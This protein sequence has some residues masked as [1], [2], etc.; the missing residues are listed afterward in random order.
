MEGLASPRIEAQAAGARPWLLLLVL[1][2]TL[3]GA[4]GAA[5]CVVAATVAAFP[6]GMTLSVPDGSADLPLSTEIQVG[7]TGWDTRIVTAEL[8][9]ASVA[10]GGTSGAERP[11]P[12]Q[13][14]ILRASQ[15]PDGTDL[16]L[17][18]AAGSLDADA[19]YR[20][21]LR[22]SALTAALPWP[23]ASPVEREVRFTTLR[24]PTPRALAGPVHLKWSQPLQIQWDA[25]V[26]DVRYEVTPPTPIQTA[27]DPSSHRASS[28]VLTDP[29]DGQTYQIAVVD[30]RGANG[31]ALR[32]RAEYTVVAPPRPTLLDADDPRTVELTKPVSL[33]FSVPIDHVA[34]TIDPPAKTT[35]QVDR[36]DPTSVQVSF[37]GLAQ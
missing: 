32:Q 19:S 6:P 22:A 23:Q 31:I 26:D 15:R 21:V 36:R 8:Y 10:P 12:V 7:L 33:K 25:P 2:T 24:S 20:L 37:D 29:E 16:T 35:W 4:I 27:I 30:A 14:T 5:L 3:V 9:E 13:A 28:V 11:V 17:R 34:L 18:P 1:G